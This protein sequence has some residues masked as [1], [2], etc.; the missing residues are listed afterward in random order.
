MTSYSFF[1]GS[2]GVGRT[3]TYLAIDMAL[4]KIENEGVVDISSI[5]VRMRQQRM[6]M[7]QTVV[8]V[9][10]YVQ[11]YV[12]SCFPSSRCLYLIMIPFV[13]HLGSVHFHF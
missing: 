11:V 3:G 12:P 7:V 5:I 8:S 6:K 1:L 9:S 4:E 13:F 2:A 10:C